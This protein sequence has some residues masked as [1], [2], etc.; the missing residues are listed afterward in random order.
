MGRYASNRAASGTQHLSCRRR[1]AKDGQRQRPAGHTSGAAVSSSPSPSS[2]ALPA[3]IQQQQRQQQPLDPVWIALWKQEYAAMLQ[4][5]SVRYYRADTSTDAM[6][7]HP[8]GRL[9]CIR[10]VLL[11]ATRL[12]T[13]ALA[14]LTALPASLLPVATVDADG[15]QEGSSG[16]GSGSHI[17]SVG[18]GAGAGAGA[19]ITN[20]AGAEEMLLEPLPVEMWLLILGMIRWCDIGA[21]SLGFGMQGQNCQVMV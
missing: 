16:S 5:W 17:A 15:V 12:H 10:T 21:P 20:T 3:D 18:A 19:D 9:D 14:A 6:L 2:L 8:Q 4:P 7:V 11:V 1:A 13:V